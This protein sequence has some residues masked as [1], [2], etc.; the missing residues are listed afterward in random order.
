[1]FWFRDIL[2]AA[3]IAVPAAGAELALAARD[4]VAGFEMNHGDVLRFRLRNGQQRTMEL[5]RT[6]ARVLLTNLKALKQPQPDGGLLYEMAAEV[7]LDGHPLRL[8]RYVSAQETF[9][10]PYVVNGMRLWLDAVDD[11]FAFVA[12]NHGGKAGCRMEKRARFAANDAADRIAPVDLHPW[13]PIR[14][15]FLDIGN[16]YNG[17]DPYLGAYQGSE[18]H[19]GAR[20][21]PAERL[22]AVRARRH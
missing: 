10:E 22:A 12:D 5:V 6:E 20:C 19:A 13:Y 7:R 15:Y 14:K 2:L 9:A 21:Q 18:C 4:T 1:M 3:M 11:I 8:V 16:S 17:D